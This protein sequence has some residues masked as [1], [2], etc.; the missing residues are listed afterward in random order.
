MGGV[1]VTPCEL[2]G[3]H[4]RMTSMRTIA[5][6]V[7]AACLGFAADSKEFK[8]T[9]PLDANGR[10]SLDT[11][12]GSIHV[13]AWDQPQ[14]D[15]QARIVEDQGWH[16]MPVQDVD[17]RVDASAGTVRVKTDYRK[18]WSWFE[19]SGNLPNVYYTI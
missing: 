2:F 3:N 10:F 1:R 16:S 6:L 14:V 17:I 13:T 19:D 12:K 8:K 11:Y 7:S 4:R 9:V 5:I 15:I 18:H